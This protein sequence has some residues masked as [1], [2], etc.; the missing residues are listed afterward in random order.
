MQFCLKMARA[1]RLAARN[2]LFAA[3][4]LCGLSAPVSAQDTRNINVVMRHNDNARTGQY[5]NETTLN[6]ANVN[7]AQFGLLFSLPVT[8]EIYAQPLYVSN[9]AI[10]GGTHDV[11]FVATAHNDLYAYDATG[12]NP[13]PYWR[14]NLGPSVP[15]GII[16]TPNLPVEVGII[17]TPAIDVTAGTMYVCCKDYVN[18]VQRFHLHAIDLATGADKQAAVE[19]AAKTPGGGAGGDTDGKGNVVFQPGKHNQRCAVTLANGNIYLAFASHEDY[20]PY[21]GWVLSYA[22]ATLTQNGVHCNTPNGG[23]GGIWMSGE[24]LPVD[25]AGNLYY[26]GGNGTYNGATGSG[27]KWNGTSNLGESVVKLNPD[28]SVADWFA[29]QNYDYLNSIDADLSSSGAMLVPGPTAS[30]Q[31]LLAGGKEGKI[32]VFDPANMTKFHATTD[33]VYQEWQ[34]SGSHIHSSMAYWNGPNGP[35]VYLWGESDKLKSFKF[36]NGYFQTTP[37]QTSTM[38]VYPGYANGPGLAVSA[39]GA[40]GGV[41]WASLP[42]DGDAVHQHVGGILRAFDATDVS[43]ELWNSKMSAGDDSGVWAKWTPPVI[44]KGKLYQAT[45]SGKLLVY[46]VLPPVAPAAPTNLTTI[47][48]NALIAL[49]WTAAPHATSYKVRRSLTPGGPYTLLSSSV[50]NPYYTDSAVTNGTTYYYVVSAINAYGESPLSNE[51]SAKPSVSAVGGSFGLQFAGSAVPITPGELAGVV[52][53]TNWNSAAGSNGALAQIKDNLGLPSGVGVTYAAAGT[54]TL[55]LADSP[56]NVRLMNGY[57]DTT[58]TSIT[59]VS[60]TGLPASFTGS[61]YD[62]YVYC[63]GDGVNRAG[64]YTIGNTA[65]RVLD[66]ALFS[67][68]FIP[69]SNSAGNYVL[70]NGL[71]GSGF[72]LTATPDQSVNGVRAPINAIQIVARAGTL[73]APANLTAAAGNA[74]VALNWTASVGAS[75]YKVRRGFAP[76]G[77]YTTLA[78]GVTATVYTDSSATNGTTYYYVVAANSATASSVN[79]NEAS[80]TPLKP[81]FGLTITPGS[82]SLVQGANG[83]VTVAAPGIGGLADY[84]TLSLSGL[85]IGVTAALTPTTIFTDRQSVITLTA[86]PLAPVATATVTVTAVSGSLSHSATFTVKVL[87]PASAG[88]GVFGI[89]FQGG[90]TGGTDVTPLDPAELAGVVPVA[91]WNNAPG[92]SG[93]ATA[94]ADSGGAA[95]GVS[96]T[97]DSANTWDSGLADNPGDFRLMRGYLDTGSSTTT[98]V[99]V[100]GLDPT[101]PY[102]FYLYASGDAAGRTGVYG[103]GDQQVYLATIAPFSGTYLRSTGTTPADPNATG[104]Y[105]VLR[106]SGS[107]T[108]TVTATPEQS[109]NGFRAPLNAVQI[110]AVGRTVSGTITLEGATNPAQPL[111][112]VFRDFNTGAPLLTQTQTLTPIAGTANGTFQITGVPARKYNLAIKSLVNLQKVVPVN[113]VT[114]DA[115]NLIAALPAGDGNN[116]NSVDS[117]DFTLLI[118]AY[119]SDR[120]VPGSGYDPRAD[121]NFDGSVDSSDFTLLIGEFNKVG[122]N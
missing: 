88:N 119:N 14:V 75:G 25:S 98:T 29:P 24:G 94:L 117:S 77:P 68:N 115:P 83:T 86:D 107:D 96:V 35:T 61:G 51:D 36:A 111:T 41:L 57:L 20:G 59:T 112:F 97:W 28:A 63:N 105:A 47:A 50:A 64:I 72:T 18:N 40:A 15:S 56:G 2:F 80:A 19:I 109:V 101:M 74:K 49:N 30:G 84:V 69:A 93:A 66:N 27:G 106:V 104:N 60:V 44:V 16:G 99:T 81:D 43:K 113:A 108:Y 32:Y 1:L 39:N 45:F 11:V 122:D 118:G 70:F 116:D 5:L 62:V 34:A 79:S 23:A 17:S 87:A 26:V 13:T 71:S 4:P 42:Y 9:L 121:F 78:T 92:Q 76:G 55:G 48:G 85:P 90:Y 8:G 114:G 10:A 89:N 53:A 21:H 110:V 31:L 120:S 103:V 38:G 46:G 12:Q 95:T 52:P 54:W 65:I 67:G 7:P 100:G 102:D 6:A 37:T 82:V 58:D 91:N 33:T 3:L 73:P 22:A